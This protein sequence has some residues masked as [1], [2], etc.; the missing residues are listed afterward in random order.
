MLQKELAVLIG[1]SAGMLSRLAKRGMPIDSYERAVRWRKR[2][3]EP[4]RIK[5]VRMDSVE[6]TGSAPAPSSAVICAV[7]ARLDELN[8]DPNF[9]WRKDGLE[10]RICASLGL[11]AVLDFERHAPTLRILM[12]MIPRKDRLRLELPADVYQRLHGV[13]FLA[14]ITSGCVEGAALVVDPDDE[15]DDAAMLLM[16]Q[17]ACGE[18]RFD[19]ARAQA[20]A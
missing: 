8:A 10:L 2:H 5:G 19:P 18:L 9:D 3:L 1:I 7:E 16:F 4:G 13:D 20:A 15:P 17:V 14:A 6:V 11:L 12:R